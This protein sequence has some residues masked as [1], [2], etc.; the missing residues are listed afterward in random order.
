MIRKFE[1]CQII[2]VKGLTFCDAEKAKYV[3]SKHVCMLL[4]PLWKVK[5]QLKINN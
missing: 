2:G 4:L 1:S 3:A 5:C